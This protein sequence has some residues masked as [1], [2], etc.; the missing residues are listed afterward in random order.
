MLELQEVVKVYLRENFRHEVLKGISFQVSQG[1]FFCILGPSGCGKTTLLR[2]I[3]GYEK[4]SGGR[5]LLQ[6]EEITGPGP[7]R[8]MV[9]Q[10]FDQLFAWQTVRGNVEYPLKIN[11]MA[12]GERRER[13]D[14]YIEMVGLK[15]YEN[16]YPHQLSGGMKQRA[17][18]ARALALQPQ[19]LLL[20]EPFASLD[21]QNREILQEELL[22]IWNSLKP[23]VI[24]VTHAVDEAII[25][26]DRI[27]V[28]TE[29]G[30]IKM[31]VENKLQRPRRPGMPGFARM[32]DFLYEQ[33]RSSRWQA[34]KRKN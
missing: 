11:G 13:A 22:R 27:L 7:D 1:E 19:I 15:G 29:D 30:D 26:A 32:W 20:D 12:R 3:G 16:Y 21:A 31:I 23:T 4:V 34:E 5:I 14:F 10:T 6:G 33:V 9:F 18:L 25:L 28:M 2:M 24:F 17:A 8:I